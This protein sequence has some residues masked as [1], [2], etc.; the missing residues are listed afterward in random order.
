MG[1]AERAHALLSASGAHRW[2]VCTP[3]AKLEE[4]FPDTTSEAAREGTLAHEL[5]ELKARHYF[6]TLDFGNTTPKPAPAQTPKLSGNDWV[7]R[8]QKE[9]NAQGFSRQVVDSIPGKNTLA[10][11]PTCRK[12]ARGNITRLIQERLNSL[13]FNCGKVDGI[14]GAGT[15][16]AVIAFQKA[17]GLTPDGIVGQNTWRVLLGM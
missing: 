9:C 10:G 16:A 5:A 2:L 7:R 12:G 4:G 13:G 3:S 8:L 15:Y 6:Y 1:H 17:H 11:C 14:F